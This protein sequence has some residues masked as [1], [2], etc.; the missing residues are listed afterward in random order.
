MPHIVYCCPLCK[1]VNIHQFPTK[2][3][4]NKTNRFITCW[5]CSDCEHA[6]ENRMG[7]TYI[8]IEGSIMN[9]MIMSRAV[10]PTM[11]DKLIAPHIVIS[12]C[13]PHNEFVEIPD[14]SDRIGYIQLKYTD[15]DRLTNNNT[16][17]LFTEQQAEEILKLV[18]SVGDRAK[19]IICQCDGGVSR[20]SAT[21]AA[22][23]KIINDDDSWVFKSPQYVP[24]MLV[25]R[26][27]LNVWHDKFIGV[28][29]HEEKEST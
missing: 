5:F 21:A 13:E 9:F 8:P 15:D 3:R 1:S 11:N 16:G 2:F 25:Y 7:R 14:N 28:T 26:T 6:F 19:L 23:S 24:N 22:L 17:K 10:I 29:G 4:G 18:E 12:I 20:S 27:I